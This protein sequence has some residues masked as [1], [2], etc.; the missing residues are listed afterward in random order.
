[1][2]EYFTQRRSIPDAAVKRP[3]NM[4]QYAREKFNLSPKWRWIYLKC[5]G[6]T[7]NDY[8]EIKGGIYD[9]LIER[10][11]RKGSTNYKIPEPGSE[12]TVSVMHLDYARWLVAWED[13]TGFCCKCNGTGRRVAGIGQDGTKYIDCRPCG[14]TGNKIN[15]GFRTCIDNR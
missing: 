1:M 13:E 3:P 2:S 15:G 11:P 12:I 8:V 5:K 6:E 4:E 10:G 7:P 14:G 9:H